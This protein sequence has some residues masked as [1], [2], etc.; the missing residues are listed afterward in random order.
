MARRLPNGVN[1]EWLEIGFYRG[2]FKGL[3]VIALIPVIRILVSS[4]NQ[5]NDSSE[6]LVRTRHMLP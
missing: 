5:G 6:Y 1:L 2:E 3:T 4:P